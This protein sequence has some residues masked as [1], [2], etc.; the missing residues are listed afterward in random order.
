MK[1]TRSSR[2]ASG[3][4]AVLPEMAAL[5]ACCII[6]SAFELIFTPTYYLK[7]AVKLVLF[8]M[9]P[10]SVLLI[11]GNKTF[12]RC[13]KPNIKAILPMLALGVLVYGIILGAY[14][15]LGGAF[16]L[17]GIAASLGEI[18]V[19]SDNFIFVAIYIAVCNSFLEEFVFRG[20]GFIGISDK[21]G[22]RRACLFSA[23]CF[24][25]YHVSMMLGWYSLWLTALIILALFVAGAVLNLLDRRS[26]TIYPAWIVHIFANLAINTV[27]MIL[28]GML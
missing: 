4:S 22:E 21:L 2:N 24:A 20:F 26:K 23:A 5:V 11:R 25:L 17:S 14:L 7:S 10:V 27:G 9:V 3:A 16:D 15:L 18:G 19:T 1:N 13:L 28:L 12:F 8:V 6:M